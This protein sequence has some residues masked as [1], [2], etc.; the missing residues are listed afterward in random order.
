[1]K[2]LEKAV[3]IAGGQT[4]LAAAISEISGCAVK[5]QHVYHWLHMARRPAPPAEYVLAIERVTGVS[6]HRLR[7]DIYP[8]PKKLQEMA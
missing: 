2:A 7:P 6:R 5:Q 3:A 1:M 4:A 8:V